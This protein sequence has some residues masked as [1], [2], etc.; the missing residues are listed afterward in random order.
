MALIAMAVH[1][2]EEN[3]RSKLTEETLLSIYKTVDLKKHRFI[4]VDNGSSIENRGITDAFVQSCNN[5]LPEQIERKL[6]YSFPDRE[7]DNVSKI[8]LEKNI[9]TAKAIN[10]AWKERKPGEHCIKMDNDVII[11]QS[12]WVDEMEE[13][14]EREPQIGIC[15]L[16]RKDLWQHPGH[17]DRMYKSELIMLPHE[18]GQRWIIAEKT[19]DIMGTCTMF[20]SALLDK[21][22]YLF[23]PSLYGYDDVLASLRSNKAG[24]INV[25]LTHINIDH[26]DPGG[27]EYIDWKHKE[28]GKVTQEVIKIIDEYIAG[29]RSIYHEA[30]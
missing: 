27:T 4:I 1:D 15:G 8:Q 28:S 13:A 10:L 21:I 16:K 30:S 2:T 22:G 19:R 3:K 17:P 9:G 23:Q 18:P 7:S 20:N 25:F 24:F 12:G 29:T 5:T 26:I 6:M 14:I 11:N